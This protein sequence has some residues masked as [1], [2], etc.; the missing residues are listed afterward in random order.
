MDKNKVTGCVFLDL[1]EAFDTVNHDLLQRKLEGLGVT[2]SSLEWFR[3]YLSQRSQVTVVGKCNSTSLPLTIGVPQ[4]SI[5]GPLLFIIYVNDLPTCLE[6]TDVTTYADDTVI[7]CEAESSQDFQY[8]LDRD[9]RNV[10]LWFTKNKLSLSSTKSKFILIGS[11][12]RLSAF[13]SVQLNIYGEVLAK[14]ENF[15]YLGVTINTNLTWHNHICNIQSKVRQKL[16]ILGRIRCHLPIYENFL[17][18]NDQAAPWLCK[19]HMR[20]QA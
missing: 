4:G 1:T 14:V 12:Q 13:S 7:Y 9:L 16:A 8:K 5:L 15:K 19:Y 11:P 18:H 10:I 6:C 17:Q 2:G 20:R 3:S